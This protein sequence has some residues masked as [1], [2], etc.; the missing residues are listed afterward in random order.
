MTVPNA[1]PINYN[2]GSKNGSQSQ[3]DNPSNRTDDKEG[4][5]IDEI[6]AQ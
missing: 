4:G 2:Q 5:S 3:F 6:L 1:Q